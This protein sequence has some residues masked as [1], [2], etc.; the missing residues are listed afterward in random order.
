M[1]AQ[2]V[3]LNLYTVQS[4]CKHDFFVVFPFVGEETNG[5]YLFA[6]KLNGLNGLALLLIWGIYLHTADHLL[7]MRR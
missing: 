6:N 2:A 7:E 5:S 3:F 1:E 4:S